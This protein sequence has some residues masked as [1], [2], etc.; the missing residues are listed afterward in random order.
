MTQ[1][2]VFRR[3]ALSAI[4]QAVEWYDSQSEGLAKRFLE[5]VDDAA[6]AIARNPYQYQKVFGEFRRVALRIFP[7][8]LIYIPTD[9]AVLVLTC[10]HNKRD[11]SREVAA[12]SG[13]P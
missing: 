3:R 9:D 1:K 4:A 6:V 11:L 5:A 12:G 8:N 2:V 13:Q 10:I 7:Y